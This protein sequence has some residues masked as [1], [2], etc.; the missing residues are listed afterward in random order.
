M[1]PIVPISMGH[2]ARDALAVQGYAVEWHE[3]PMQH[4]VCAAELVVIGRW[5][6]ARL[7]GA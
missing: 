4:E 7:A 3:Y 5:L 6:Q 1:D 2:E